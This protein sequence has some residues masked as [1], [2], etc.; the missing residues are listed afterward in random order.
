MDK[1]SGEKYLKRIHEDI[2]S[3]G[4]QYELPWPVLSRVNQEYLGYLQKTDG[5]FY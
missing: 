1:I 3:T 2:I 5:N 4:Q